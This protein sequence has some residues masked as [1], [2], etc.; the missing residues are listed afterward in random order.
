MVEIEFSVVE[1]DL[2]AVNDLLPLMQEFEKQYHIHVNITA[3]PWDGA[4]AQNAKFAIYGHGPDV[5]TI[6]SSWLG[7]LASMEAVRHFTPTEVQAL[8]SANAYFDSIWQ[9]GLLLGDPNP[10]AIPW[11]G[12][13]RVLYYWKGELK[14]MG[15]ENFDEAFKTD[16]ALVATLET[17]RKNGCK[18]PLAITT[19]AI[20]QVLHE[21]A[22]WIWNAGGDF[23]SPDGKQVTFNQPK[24]LDGLKNYFRLLPYINP[25]TS[26]IA[27]SFFFD[28]K[29]SPLHIA[30]PWVPR[31]H[32][33]AV[34]AGQLCAARLPGIA[35]IGGNSF[36]IWK[37]TAKYQQ[38]FDLIRFLASQPIVH[39]KKN[40][41]YFKLPTKSESLN[42]PITQNDPFNRIYLDAFQS[43]RSFPT[44]RLWGSIEDKLIPQIANIWAELFARPDQDLDAC[45]HKHLDPLA[46][47]LNI[48]LGT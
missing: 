35:Y 32:T 14:K 18:Y 38:A 23:T 47:R 24:A 46:D 2:E 26:Q 41:Q 1:G 10:C 40:H 12:D 48:V 13:V 37:Y 9:V 11:I 21:A 36:I 34:S 42:A 27:P 15:V 29:S 6:G 7:S 44:L 20:S 31:N 5:S 3:I 30:G 45:L 4:W 28:N 33:D 43:G 17:L 25:E 16:A 22:H 19:H 39:N 8:G